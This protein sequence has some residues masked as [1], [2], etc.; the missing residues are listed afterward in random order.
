MSVAL[1]PASR[2]SR[3]ISPR[4]G[5]IAAP[6]DNII[7]PMRDPS[8]STLE[9]TVNGRRMALEVDPRTSLLDLLR[10][11]LHLTGVKKGCNQG[12]CGACTVLVN[13]RRV[14]AC[15]QL[16][17]MCHGSSV[18]TIEGLA[19]GDELHPLQDAFIR[20]DAF[21]CGY[22][23]PGQILS[24]VACIAEGHTG[25]PGEVREFMSGNICRCGAYQ[26][27]V[28]AILEVADSDAKRGP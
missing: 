2:S 16:A 14:N 13:E 25:S 3:A 27:I 6:W 21:Q 24:A 12:A 15:L 22:C 4:L 20:H 26:N 17:V 8:T 18:T 11:R 23:T 10:E 5:F 7:E 1:A 19:R 28:A 9:L